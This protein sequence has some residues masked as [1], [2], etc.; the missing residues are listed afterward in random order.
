MLP[1]C[2]FY[3]YLI[4]RLYHFQND[5]PVANVLLALTIVHWCQFLTLLN[6]CD[7]VTK[8]RTTLGFDSWSSRLIFFI[9]LFLHYV[10]L[11]DKRKWQTFNSEFKNETP[12]ERKV[13]TVVVISYCVGSIASF[14]ITLQIYDYI[15]NK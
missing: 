14:F 7:C 3:R 12:T 9:L 1:L 15:M 4:Y 8:S 10:I 11:Y 5:T 2:R 6:L 13:G